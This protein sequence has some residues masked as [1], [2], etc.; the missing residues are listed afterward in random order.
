MT[1]LQPGSL[2]ISRSTTDGWP[3]GL[4]CPEPAQGRSPA[5]MAPFLQVTRGRN[6]TVRGGGTVDAN[7][8]ITHGR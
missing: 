4:D 3:L 8:E 5:Q 6:V 2:V 7:G 1:L